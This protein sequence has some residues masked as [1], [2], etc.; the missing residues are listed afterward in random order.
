MDDQKRSVRVIKRNEQSINSILKIEY[1]AFNK[2]LLNKWSLTP[3]LRYG[4]VFGL[5]ICESMKGFVIYI[6]LWDNPNSTYL[7]ETAVEQDSQGNGNGCF[8]LLQSLQHLKESGF[9]DVYLT[10]D[11]ENSRALHIYCDK[12][13]F[14]LL[15]YRKN[16]YGQGYDRL[17]LQLN[18]DKWTPCQ[19]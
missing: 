16:E 18:L 3:Y 14:K 15:E 2:N 12:F 4:C 13:G 8:L 9:S 6:R 5:F 7:V 11:P 10:V 17:F 1:S 19:C